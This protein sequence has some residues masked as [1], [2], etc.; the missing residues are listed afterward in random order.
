MTL[1]CHMICD[2]LSSLHYQ[3]L[4]IVII[5]KVSTCD[6]RNLCNKVEKHDVE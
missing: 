1:G 3:L 6:P 5:W 2:L 4:I